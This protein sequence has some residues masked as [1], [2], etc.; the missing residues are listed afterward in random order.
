[1]FL[2]AFSLYFELLPNI[3]CPAV[4]SMHIIF[5][6]RVLW[7]TTIGGVRLWAGAGTADHGMVD[8]FCFF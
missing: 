3:F 7:S 6:D 1:M 2:C 5:S 4:S 8:S